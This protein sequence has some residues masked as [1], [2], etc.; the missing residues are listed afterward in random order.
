M[1]FNKTARRLKIK[2]S[3]RKTI[4]GTSA[5]PRLCVYRSNK[6][7]YAQLVDDL[8]GVTLTG[9]TSLKLQKEGLTKSD[10]AKEVGKVIAERATAIGIK[11]VVFDRNGFLYHGRV[12]ALAESAR[13]NGLQF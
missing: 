13:E 5:R 9:A 11:S 7:I 6:A 8:K 10:L 2:Q 12:K 1:A 4:S 3:I